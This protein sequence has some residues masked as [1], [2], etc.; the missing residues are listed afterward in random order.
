MNTHH[1]IK[2]LKLGS[3]P[4]KF[5]QQNWQVPPAKKLRKKKNIMAIIKDNN[6]QDT[7]TN[8]FKHART[9][10]MVEVNIQRRSEHG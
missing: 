7:T 6:Y 8:K 10:T 5:F 2:L 4:V 9:P 3:F 1:F